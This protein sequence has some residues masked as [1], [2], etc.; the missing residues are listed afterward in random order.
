MEVYPATK[1]NLKCPGGGIV[2]EKFNCSLE[3]ISASIVKLVTW[4]QDG[5]VA[6][7]LI[8]VGSM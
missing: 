6:A 3:I 8:D 1:V 2:Y 7:H 4:M 5:Q